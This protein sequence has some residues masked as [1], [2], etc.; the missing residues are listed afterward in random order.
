LYFLGVDGGGS[1]TR[2]LLIDE[3]GNVLAESR[4]ESIHILQV[5][6]DSFKYNFKEGLKAICEKANI[7]VNEIDYT[8][9]GVPGYGDEIRNEKIN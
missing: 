6:R 8:F 7:L 1:K 9:I 2:Y 4:T 5:G 3:K